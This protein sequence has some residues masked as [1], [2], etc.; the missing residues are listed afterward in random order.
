LTVVVS[1]KSSISSGVTWLSR[2]FGGNE[3]VSTSARPNSTPHKSHAAPHASPS[4]AESV[5]QD[6]RAP[7]LKKNGVVARGL[8]EFKAAQVL[9]SSFVAVYVKL[10][11]HG[12]TS[13]ETDFE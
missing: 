7:N 1:I 5:P 12:K 8:P 3:I 4:H 6:G 2:F 11:L 13:T 10:N 9:A